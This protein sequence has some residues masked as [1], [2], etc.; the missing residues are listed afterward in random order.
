MW[1]TSNAHTFCLIEGGKIGKRKIEK[2]KRKRKEFFMP[3]SFSF[4]FHVCFFCL[5]P[6]NLFFIFVVPKDYHG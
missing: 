5:L 3:V 1:K 2:G 6:F 4:Y